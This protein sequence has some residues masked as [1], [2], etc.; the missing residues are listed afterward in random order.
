VLAL[1][2]RRG[3]VKNELGAREG[4]AR[5]LR[6]NGPDAAIP[7]FESALALAATIGHRS[8][9]I[10]IGNVLG[11]LEWQRGSYSDALRRYESVLA[12]MRATN[13]ERLRNRADEAVTLNS[14]GA[15]LTRLGRRDEARTVLNESLALS[16]ELGQR[17]LEAHALATLGHV[18][19]TAYD[20]RRA[21]ECFEESLA[22]RR[23]IG[24][25]VGEGWMY[26]R[27][28]ELRQRLEDGA[29]ARAAYEAASSAATEVGDAALTADCA[30]ASRRF[31]VVS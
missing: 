18:F 11:I 7:A 12:L 5:A 29:G 16:R 26:L 24:D 14:I 4:L 22:I 23:A 30:R 31:G 20:V 3:D 17:Q 6:A 9:E 2:R 25:R 27:L 1:H 8:R 10:A 28:A 13:D 21:V 19:S 15:C